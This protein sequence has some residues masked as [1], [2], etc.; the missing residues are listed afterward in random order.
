MSNFLKKNEWYKNIGIKVEKDKITCDYCGGSGWLYK[1]RDP[2]D[3]DECSSCD[4]EGSHWEYSY[5]DLSGKKEIKLEDL[6]EKESYYDYKKKLNS[7]YDLLKKNCSKFYE[8]H[9]KQIDKEFN[10]AIIV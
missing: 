9:K 10:N 6:S 8:K 7:D 2:S 3:E 4:G 5:W 1:M